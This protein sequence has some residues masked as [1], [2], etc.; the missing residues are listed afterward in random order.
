MAIFVKSEGGFTRMS[1]PKLAVLMKENEKLR[2][3]YAQFSVWGGG[4]RYRSQWLERVPFVSTLN[5]K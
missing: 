3:N 1:T 4:G 2:P 5:E